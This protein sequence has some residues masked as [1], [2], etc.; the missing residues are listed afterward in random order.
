MRRHIGRN[1][2]GAVTRRGKY[3]WLPISK[4]EATGGLLLHLGFTR[5]GILR[6]L[7]MEAALLC[8]VGAL[9]GL[10][11]GLGVAKVKTVLKPAHA[12]AA[13][14]STASRI[15]SV[16]MIFLGHFG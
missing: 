4:P 14:G 11:L 15:N 7:A 9:A 16:S 5:A 2:I 12:E 3:L 6:L 10:A 13:K 1:G 8:G